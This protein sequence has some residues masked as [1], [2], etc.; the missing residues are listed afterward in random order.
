MAKKESLT[1]MGFF[2]EVCIRLRHHYYNT[3]K[4]EEIKRLLKKRKGKC[5]ACSK[6]CE[7]KFFGLLTCSF[8]KNGKCSIYKKQPASCRNY[9]F[10]KKDRYDGKIPELES[11]CGYYWVEKK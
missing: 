1:K 11:S 8:L 2:D 4:K 3:F 10:D 5:K 6:C 7:I 9:P